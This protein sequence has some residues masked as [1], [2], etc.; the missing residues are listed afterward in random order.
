[1]STTGQ[2]QKPVKKSNNS[3]AIAILLGQVGVVTL[4]IILAALFGGLALDA[5]FGTKPWITLGLLIISMPV[6]ILLMVLIARRTAKKLKD[7]A[8][9]ELSKEDVIGKDS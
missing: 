8:T 6:T 7:S 4:V 2:E 9:Q 5:R 1:M 3:W